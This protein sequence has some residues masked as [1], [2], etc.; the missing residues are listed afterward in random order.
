MSPIRFRAVILTAVSTWALKAS[1][2]NPSL[3]RKKE[4][5]AL[6]F[7]EEKKILLFTRRKV[8]K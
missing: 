5:E 1:N 3:E 6:T 8:V 7:F 4:R 2:D